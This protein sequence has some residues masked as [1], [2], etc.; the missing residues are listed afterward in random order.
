MYNYVYYSSTGLIDMV[1]CSLL[2]DNELVFAYF[3][4]VYRFLSYHVLKATVVLL[5]MRYTR[6]ALLRF[7]NHTE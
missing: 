2:T 4:E 5:C 7:V 1:D 6:M 3:L